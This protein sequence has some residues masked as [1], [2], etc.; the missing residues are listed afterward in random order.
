MQRR[1]SESMRAQRQLDELPGLHVGQTASRL[2][3]V[4]LPVLSHRLVRLHEGLPEVPDGGLPLVGGRELQHHHQ[5]AGRDRG[6]RPHQGQE[7]L[8]LISTRAP[9]ALAASRLEHG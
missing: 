1:I 2:F 3:R 6:G 9:P 8:I 4:Q 7:I 5:R